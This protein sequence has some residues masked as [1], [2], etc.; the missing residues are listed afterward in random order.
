MLVDGRHARRPPHPQ[1]GHGQD[2]V[3]ADPDG[4]GSRALGWDVA[5]VFARSMMPFFPSE[6]VDPHRV[7]R[8]L[9]DDR[10]GTSGVYLI[11]LTNRVH[12]SGGGAAKI[13]ELRVRVAGAVGAALFA[14]SGPPPVAQGES[15]SPAADGPAEPP[16][17]TVEPAPSAPAAPAI[18]APVRRAPPS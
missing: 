6:S 3:D 10:S 9:G 8:H 1:A 16:V 5:S 14:S 15:V 17:A 12:P 18:A 4:S 7:H 2:D 13:R 11:V